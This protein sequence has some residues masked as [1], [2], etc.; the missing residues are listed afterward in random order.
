[1]LINN[2]VLEEGPA[3]SKIFFD[4][5]EE[6]ATPSNHFHGRSSSLEGF[7]SCEGEDSDMNF[8]IE[9]EDTEE[10]FVWLKEL[11]HE[12]VEETMKKRARRWRERGG[13]AYRNNVL[14]G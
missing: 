14:K 7:S 13:G 8:G 9:E 3:H 12:H 10:T 2:N 5:L 6:F 1:V 4:M 11:L